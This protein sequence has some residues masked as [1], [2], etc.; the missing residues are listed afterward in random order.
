VLTKSQRAI[1]ASV[2]ALAAAGG[3]SF[4]VI[5]AVSPAPALVAPA[6]LPSPAGSAATATVPR[7]AGGADGAGSG[8]A[9]TA[10]Q[11][12]TPAPAPGSG[13]GSGGIPA[14]P[15]SAGQGNRG[16][17]PSGTIPAD[18]AVP[19][20]SPAIQALAAARAATTALP[21]SPQ[22]LA[23]GTGTGTGDS[24]AAASSPVPSS[25]A[26]PRWPSSAASPTASPAASPT[27]SS[28]GSPVAT[29]SAAAA[30]SP[31]PSGSAVPTGSPAPAGS[32]ASPAG[33]P[34]AGG[35]TAAAAGRLAAASAAQAPRTVAG[36]DVAAFQHPVSKQFP[37]GEAI[38]WTA[39]AAAGY[40]YAA[41]K[42][43]EGDYYVNPWAATDLAKAKA[44]G[45]DVAPYHFAVPN[46]S[47]G[48]AQ[49]Q[50]AVE[51]SGYAPGTRML[52]LMLDIEY[53]P[54]VQADHTNECYGLTPAQMTAWLSA[55]AST[56]RSLTGQYPVIY[57]TADWWDTCTGRSAAL[58][59]DPMWVAA[60]G[61]ASPPVP[62]GWH[63]WTFWQYT[64]GGTVPGVA[65]PG[66]TDLDSFSPAA[67]GLIDPG[68]QSSLAGARVSL[69]V[70]SLGAVAGEALKY[71][72]AGLPPGLSVTAGGTIT[73]TVTAAPAK[74]ATY[75]VT[76]SVTNGAG[77]KATAA[78]SWQVNPAR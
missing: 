3:G 60:Y 77:A 53:D 14:L 34:S 74:A 71:A 31:A 46:V 75:R 33:P 55:F 56:A 70:G 10:G 59:A 69:P 8:S 54:Y 37:G 42:A 61:F 18:G 78:F 23:A 63:A 62:A 40:R 27:L 28:P 64:S 22:L 57:T 72:A 48:A 25:A 9:G 43:T 39:V 47:G 7:G 50:F 35:P 66:T 30:G 4:A 2:L 26:P 15:R 29:G 5:R 76:L 68:G 1:A 19:G 73:G 12:G 11:Q 67:V 49:A 41:V 32:A 36:L 16:P 24:A 44:A 20:A 38:S 17:L 21:H 51:Y 6:A 13:A 65:T 52:P 58:G 45:L